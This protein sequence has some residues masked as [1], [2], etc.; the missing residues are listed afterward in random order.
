[1]ENMKLSDLC[2][3]FDGKFVTYRQLIKKMRELIGGLTSLSKED[4]EENHDKVDA[5]FN[6][7]GRVSLAGNRMMLEELSWKEI[8]GDQNKDYIWG[9]IF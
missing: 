4:L 7:I 9:G 2:I 3:E 6:E 1:M 8:L 5:I